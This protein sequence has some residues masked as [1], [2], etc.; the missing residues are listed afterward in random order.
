MFSLLGASG[1]FASGVGATM[2]YNY[3][4][5][6]SIFSLK[7]GTKISGKV[8][9]NMYKNNLYLYDRYDDKSPGIKTNQTLYDTNT[10]YA[11]GLFAFRKTKSILILD[12]SQLTVC[13]ESDDYSSGHL[14]Y[15]KI[16]T[17]IVK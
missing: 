6:P 8:Y 9:K 2:L 11:F 5:K 17:L 1:L 3:Y 4:K 16:D 14:D 7:P 13:Y 15:V 10:I 12:D